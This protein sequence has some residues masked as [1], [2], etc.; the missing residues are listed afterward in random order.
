MTKENPLDNL[1][2]LRNV[3]MVI[4]RGRVIDKPKVRINKLVEQE[5]DKFL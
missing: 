1:A 4:A 2:A 5:L 3:D